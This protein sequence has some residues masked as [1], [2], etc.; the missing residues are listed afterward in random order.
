MMDRHATNSAEEARDVVRGARI[1]EICLNFERHFR[2]IVLLRVV[3][4]HVYLSIIIN[5]ITAGFIVRYSESKGCLEIENITVLLLLLA[6]NV[7]DMFVLRF[8]YSR[9]SVSH[10]N[11]LPRAADRFGR[12]KQSVIM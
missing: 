3:S 5:R 8:G 6:F 12:P 7:I 9:T 11:I 10:H 1:D 4:C 2:S